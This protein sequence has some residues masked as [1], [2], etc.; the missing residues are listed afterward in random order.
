MTN[1]KTS[2]L[3]P[4][5]EAVVDLLDG[6]DAE[7]RRALVVERAEPLRAVRCRAPELRARADDLGE[8][9]GVPDPLA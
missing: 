5:A 1:L 3:G 8:V 9:D 6:V 2:P 4:A 7:R